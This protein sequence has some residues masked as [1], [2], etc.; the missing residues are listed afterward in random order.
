MKKSTKG[1]ATKKTVA[2][3]RVGAVTVA[4]GYPFDADAVRTVIA[5]ELLKVAHANAVDIPQLTARQLYAYLRDNRSSPLWRFMPSD[6]R[7]IK[8]AHV[9][10]CRRFIRSV[11]IVSA[12]VP[13]VT[14]EPLFV[15]LDDIP[16]SRD[17][18]GREKRGRTNILAK[19]ARGRFDLS[20]RV[21]AARASLVIA[22]FKQLEYWCGSASVSDHYMKLVADVRA[23]L[24]EFESVRESLRDRAA[25]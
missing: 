17:E 3:P 10:M 14:G 20:T 7:A 12:A 24:D 22:A 25:E 2:G 6:E 9:E 15:N 18:R 11:R 4:A 16:V 21:A 23:A 8:M 1:P 5:P 13:N 19:D